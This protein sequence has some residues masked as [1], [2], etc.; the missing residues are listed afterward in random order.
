MISEDSVQSYAECLLAAGFH[1]AEERVGLPMGS[2]LWRFS[3]RS[4]E[5]EM[6][7]DRGE[8]YVTIGPNGVKARFGVL[9]WARLLGVELPGIPGFDGQFDFFLAHLEQIQQLIDD[10]ENIVEALREQNWSITKQRLGIDPDKP[11]PGRSQ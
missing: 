7:V 1:L 9:T 11:R 6:G 10:H 8:E 4:M 5:L 2:A 3:S